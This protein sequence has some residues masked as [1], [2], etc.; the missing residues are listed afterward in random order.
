MT[1]YAFFRQP[2]SNCG[3][4]VNLEVGHA[5]WDKEISPG[6]KRDL[7]GILEEILPLRDFLVPRF[8]DSLQNL[9]KTKPLT[10]FPDGPPVAFGTVTPWRPGSLEEESTAQNIGSTAENGS[11]KKTT[12]SQEELLVACNAADLICFTLVNCLIVLR[13]M[14]WCYFWTNHTQ[15][16][17]TNLVLLNE[18]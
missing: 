9:T 10:T 5:E 12:A 13:K 18:L 3:S 11:N 16:V 15:L 6:L 2:S 8:V 14:T 4:R 7:L 1:R 17:R